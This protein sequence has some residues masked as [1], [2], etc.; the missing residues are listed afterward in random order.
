VLCE[1]CPG[2]AHERTSLS[3]EALKLL[4]AYGRMDVEALA[5][6]RVAAGVEREVE[7][8]MREFLEYTLDRRPKSLAFLDEI[9]AGATAT[10]PVR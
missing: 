9:R 6:L 10:A 4:K 5:G 1:R 3:L 2:P 8:A 7:R